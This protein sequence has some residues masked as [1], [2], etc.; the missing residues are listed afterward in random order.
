M[1][2]VGAVGA[3][4]TAGAVPPAARFSASSRVLA[5]NA[6]RFSMMAARSAAADSAWAG[7]GVE[8]GAAASTAAASAAA[9]ACPESD[10]DSSAPS[11]R[12]APT[13][14]PAAPTTRLRRA[15]RRARG[16]SLAPAGS[17][18][19]R[20]TRAG[21][22]QAG[23]G[24]RRGGSGGAPASSP[25]H[26][27][28]VGELR[29]A[30]VP[31]HAMRSSAACRGA[32]FRC[33]G[34]GSGLS[35]TRRPPRA[36]LPAGG[37]A[38]PACWRSRSRMRPARGA[39]GAMRPLAR[40]AARRRRR[41]GEPRRPPRRA[42]APM[43][44]RRAPALHRCSA[45]GGRSGV[46]RCRLPRGRP[47]RPSPPPQAGRPAPPRRVRAPR[48][49]PQVQE[50]YRGAGRSPSGPGLRGVR[51]GRP[52]PN[53]PPP[54]LAHRPRPGPRPPQPPRRRPLPASRVAALRPAHRAPRRRGRRRHGQPGGRP[55]L[56]PRLRLA[57]R[58]LHVRQ[59]A[60]RVGDSGH[61]RVRHDA[62]PEGRRV[63]GL[64][65]PRRVDGRLPARLGR[66]GQALLAAQRAHHDSPTAGRGAGAGG[67]HRDPGGR[68]GGG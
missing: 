52:T 68:A 2:G 18:H 41:R 30:S 49:P 22:G 64:R 59:L 45:A 29:P 60:R 5:S 40:L 48:R 1:E 11:L 31:L 4:A 61:G 13:A 50:R 39:G 58:H 19:D 26:S 24:G 53:P 46:P 66:P 55:T 37:C 27:T 65:R 28:P 14:D 9:S 23:H 21:C 33:G 16:R 3:S 32:T 34:G 20:E 63:D 8:S 67:R 6:L 43:P 12:H 54:Q 17:R 15:R 47:R 36:A 56:V 35:P 51:G 10:G 57:R 44:A 62:V 38:G 42:G 7:G 25:P